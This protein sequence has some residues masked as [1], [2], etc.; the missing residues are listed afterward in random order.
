MHA[1]CNRQ[2]NRITMADIRNKRPATRRGQ[3]TAQRILAAASRLF[4]ERGYDAVSIEDIV[5]LAGGSKSSLYNLFTGK[6]PLFVAVI[7][8]LSDRFVE[9]LATVDISRM[10]AE[11]GL[12]RFGQR[13]L[14]I[15][16]DDRHLAFYRLAIAQA[17]NMPSVGHEWRRHGPDATARIL[18]RFIVHHQD[19][20]NL[21]T[22]F[23]ARTAARQLHDMMAFH[24]VHRAVLGDRPTRR[25]VSATI[26]SAVAL[27]MRGYGSPQKSRRRRAT[28]RGPC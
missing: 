11:E 7:A 20:G 1:A 9:Q 23:D 12:H 2:E 8:E 28:L 22:D 10:K 14:E 19:V 18:A 27:F 4:L 3:A 17:A 25:E 5:R 16:L 15:L 13:L 6:E 24:L 26:D 21:E